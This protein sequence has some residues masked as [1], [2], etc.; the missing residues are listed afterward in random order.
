[1]VIIKGPDGQI[2]T[3]IIRD[4]AVVDIQFYRPNKSNSRSFT[5]VDE[6]IAGIL[7]ENP[8]YVEIPSED[9]LGNLD[10]LKSVLRG[11]FNRKKPKAPEHP[12]KQINKNTKKKVENKVVRVSKF[13]EK[14]SL[15]RRLKHKKRRVWKLLTTDIQELFSKGEVRNAN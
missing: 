14:V 7:L 13:M 4:G 2:G 6:D 8:K 10:E 3:K 12:P 11:Q 15:G 9:Y 5:I 1:M